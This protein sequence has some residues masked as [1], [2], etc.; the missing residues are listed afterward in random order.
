[1]WA[2]AFAQDD[3]EVNIRSALANWL[4]N[5]VEELVNVPF[6]LLE[7]AEFIRDNARRIQALRLVF[8]LM[9]QT[10]K[11]QAEAWRNFDVILP[12][13]RAGIREFVIS[14]GHEIE[15]ERA[16]R[17]IKLQFR[18]NRPVIVADNA[19]FELVSLSR[20]ANRQALARVSAIVS[21]FD[22]L[23]PSIQPRER[24]TTMIAR[25]RSSGRRL[26]A[27]EAGIVKAMLARG[28]RHHDIAAWFGVNQ[29]RIAEVKGGEL[30][31]DVSPASTEL[32]PP[33]GSPGR[34]A[35]RAMQ[36]LTEAERALG[37]DDPS[38]A[39]RIISDATQIIRSA[40]TEIKEAGE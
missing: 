19:L 36:A 20:P 12:E 5:R 34:I 14:R 18:G 35:L 28:D 17:R 10:S 3:L 40:L 29:G 15:F 11:E 7:V 4:R 2:F 25:A 21:A 23:R 1:L 24:P 8:V 16:L 22:L 27:E 32:L 37:R 39:E 9:S 33:Q 6:V 26:S 31:P 30:F 38:D 13:A